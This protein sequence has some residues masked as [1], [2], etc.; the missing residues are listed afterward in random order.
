MF[1]DS[2]LTRSIA[3][4]GTIGFDGETEHVPQ[5]QDPINTA[6]LSDW[7]EQPV[8]GVIGSDLLMRNPIMIDYR[9]GQMTTRYDGPVGNMIGRTAMGYAIVEL[10]I[11]GIRCWYIVDTG[12]QY[13]YLQPGMIA[14]KEIR[15]RVV[16]CKWGAPGNRFEADLY[17]TVFECNGVEYAVGCGVLSTKDAPNLNRIG[18]SGVIG[19]DFF[20]HHAVAIRNGAVYASN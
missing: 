6:V 15:E 16:D 14:G 20:D 5:E 3:D 1:I 11:D 12:T 10:L 13:S 17:D 9:S 18:I 4:K 19:K 7:F 2:G 8:A